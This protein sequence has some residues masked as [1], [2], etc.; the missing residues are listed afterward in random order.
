MG[1]WKRE[2]LEEEWGFLSNSWK[3]IWKDD[4]GHQVTGRGSTPEEAEKDALKAHREARIRLRLPGDH[5]LRPMGGAAG[6]LPGAD[7]DAPSAG[8]SMC[9]GGRMG[10]AFWRST[11]PWRPG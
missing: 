1:S 11:P 10:R 4:E 7:P 9:A 6:R 8:G 3:S 5:R 2:R